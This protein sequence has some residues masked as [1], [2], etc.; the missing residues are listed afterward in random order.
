MRKSPT[1]GG[2][3]RN[4]MHKEKGSKNSFGQ[5]GQPLKEQKHKMAKRMKVGKE[6]P[7]KRIMKTHFA[8]KDDPIKHQKVVNEFAK[9]QSL[10]HAN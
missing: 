1:E 7:I 10:W 3:I 5:S 9:K 4:T 8:D 2:K 6:W